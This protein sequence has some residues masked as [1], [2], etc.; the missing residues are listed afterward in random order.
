MKME[1]HS[2]LWRSDRGWGKNSTE[3][4]LQISSFHISIT[5]NHKQFSE[6]YHKLLFSYGNRHCSIRDVRDANICRHPDS[7]LDFLHTWLL[8]PTQKKHKIPVEKPFPCI[9]LTVKWR[10]EMNDSRV[11]RQIRGNDRR[12]TD[13][14][15]FGISYCFAQFLSCIRLLSS[16]R[17]SWLASARHCW[18]I[19]FI[20]LQAAVPPYIWER[21][22]CEE[23]CCVGGLAGDEL[24]Y[25]RSN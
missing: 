13:W 15:R 11:Q 1:M 2:L 6:Y 10:D 12:E 19:L 22:S 14:L 7:F 18:S 21:K 20:S 3:G 8:L 23:D 16:G 24:R 17:R 25:F 9:F 4:T 5:L